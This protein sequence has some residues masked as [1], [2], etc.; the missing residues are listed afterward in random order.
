MCDEKY[1]F[2]GLL[3]LIEPIKAILLYL[4]LLLSIH[5]STHPIHTTTLSH[6]FHKSQEKVVLQFKVL[7]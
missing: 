3:P 6:G 2:P 7:T 4:H 1:F 5:D